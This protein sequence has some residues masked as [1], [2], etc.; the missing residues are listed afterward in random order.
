LMATVSKRDLDSP[1]I[2]E[3]IN[4]YYQSATLMGRERVQLFRLAWDLA[5]SGFAGRQVLY[6]RFFAGDPFLLMASRF[7]SYDRSA[8]VA[9]VKAM[10]A[11]SYKDT[12]K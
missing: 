11:R 6:E 4:R 9:R 1:E 3:E 10:L 5:C 12:E 7:L 8:A 2:G